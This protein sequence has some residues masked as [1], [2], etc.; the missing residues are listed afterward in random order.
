MNATT[1]TPCSTLAPRSGVGG[2]DV[3]N[4][5][6]SLC[7]PLLFVS[8]F[9]F[10]GC[11]MVTDKQAANE[12]KQAHP[13]ATIYEQFIGEGD[14]DHAYMHFRYTEERKPEKVEQV[15]VYQRQKDDSW[16]VIGKD[17]PKPAG[18]KFGD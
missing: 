11:G 4:N 1:S 2:L 18:S 12:F 6:N 8:A 16:K 13:K 7:L 9:L 17:G 3:R 10:A 14:S 5:M 15:W